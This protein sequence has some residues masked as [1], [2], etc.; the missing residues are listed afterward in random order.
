[1]NWQM[2]KLVVTQII[3]GS[4][5]PFMKRPCATKK[6]QIDT[7]VLAGKDYGMGPA[8]IGQLRG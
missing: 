8:A 6:M 3:K 7:I 5:Y 2:E 1:M 4:C